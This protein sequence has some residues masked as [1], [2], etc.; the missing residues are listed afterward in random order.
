[1]K[2][3]IRFEKI[4]NDDDVTELKII[5]SN[6]EIQITCRAYIGNDQIEE[7]RKELNNFKKQIHGGIY[8]YR[9]PG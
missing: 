1:M 5:T 8:D 2:S 6:G 9:N 7:I 3:F 4:W